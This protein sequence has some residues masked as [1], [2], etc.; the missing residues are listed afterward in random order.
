MSEKKYTYRLAPCPAYDVDGMEKWLAD[1]SEKGLHLSADG[2]FLGFAT[3]EKG[4]P[5][6]LKY[7]LAPADKNTSF[8]A[9]YDGEP[10]AEELELSEAYG[11]KYIAKRGEFHIYCSEDPDSRELNTDPEVYAMALKTAF[12]RRVDSAVTSF[13]WMIIYPIIVMRGAV[14]LNMINVG[15][16]FSLFG[17]ALL[18]WFFAESAVYAAKLGKLRKRMLTEHFIKPETA[19]KYSSFKYNFLRISRLVLGVVWVILI[20]RMFGIAISEENYTSL[21]S[22]T[23][24]PP[25]ATI[26]DFA[27]EGDYKPEP[28]MGIGDSTR[29]WRDVLA[30]V[31]YDWQEHAVV[32]CEDKKIE[33]TLYLDYHETVSA[34]IAKILAKEYCRYDFVKNKFKKPEPLSLP[35]LDI[36]GYIGYYDSIHVPVVVLHHGK[37]VVHA[38]FHQYSGSE[39]TVDEWVTALAESIK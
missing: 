25:F 16:L 30:P 21:D 27:P 23:E 37:K 28:F 4:S 9:S 36:D 19:P 39:M 10:D 17:F 26:A 38:S 3:F 2:F 33:G 18:L 11:W 14:L 31:N 32:T 35:D 24:D 7:R 8:Y 1:M 29:I 34:G 5:K 13:L 22:V 12:K 6:K 15:T 20:L